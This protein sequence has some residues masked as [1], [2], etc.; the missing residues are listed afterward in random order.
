[1]MQNINDFKSCGL[2]KHMKLDKSVF[3]SRNSVIYSDLIPQ[4]G[5][6]KLIYSKKILLDI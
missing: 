2:W 3:M 6:N 4:S 5:N 1:M